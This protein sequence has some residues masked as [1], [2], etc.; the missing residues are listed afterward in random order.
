[1]KK[2]KVFAALLA[3]ATLCSGCFLT[4]CGS[5]KPT[6][7]G[8]ASAP[9]P[10]GSGTSKPAAEKVT[11]E[12]YTWADEDVYMPAIVEAFNA[13]SETTQVNLTIVPS[14]ASDPDAY[15]NK[16]TALLAGGGDLDLFGT[17]VV[18]N[19]AKRRDVGNLADMTGAIQAAGIDLSRYGEDFQTTLADGKCYGLPYRFSAYALFYNKKIFDAEGVPYPEKMTWDEYA[20]LAKSLT[21][22]RDDGTKQ[23]GG[24][25]PNWMG[26]PIM[27][28][29]MGSNVLDPDSGALKEW[30]SLL[31]RIYN[32]D[33][34]H[35]SFEEMNSTSTDWLKIFLNGDV[36]MLPNGEWTVGNAK[37][38]LANIIYG[39][40]MSALQEHCF[41]YAQGAKDLDDLVDAFMLCAHLNRQNK[42][43][44]AL[45]GRIHLLESELGHEV[46]MKLSANSTHFLSIIALKLHTFFP[47][48]AEAVI[49]NS[50]EAIQSILSNYATPYAI[51][52]YFVH[53]SEQDIRQLFYYL[54]N[55]CADPLS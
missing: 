7:S 54:A 50:A 27:T 14:S 33:A 52:F 3:A 31:N 22:T 29:Q 13:Q 47:N 17:S 4:G 44:A 39:E 45:Q 30:L 1:M 24:F 9:A 49:S 36:A 26:E 41:K 15:E 38:E 23:W 18:K 5:D 21:K 12:Y 35:M 16:I 51:R 19:F 11:V 55:M 42:V 10:Q 46:L 34:S 6:S 43:I 8:S 20:V 25:L 48:A 32:E 28:V 2:R 37:Q 53:Q 40:E